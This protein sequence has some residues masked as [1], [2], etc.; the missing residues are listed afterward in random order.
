MKCFLLT[1]ISFNYKVKIKF[2]LKGLI[3]LTLESTAF[4][5]TK[6]IKSKLKGNS[7]LFS[8]ETALFFC[9]VHNT[10]FVHTIHFTHHQTII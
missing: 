8:K 6:I 1:L 3:N 9:F 2:L 7:V 10:R 4:E 5:G